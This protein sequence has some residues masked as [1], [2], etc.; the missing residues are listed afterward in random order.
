MGQFFTTIYCL[1]DDLFGLELASYLAGEATERQQS[2]MF[3]SIGLAMIGISLLVAVIF[4]YVVNHPKLN[5]WWGWCIFLVINGLINYFLG[6]RW[7]LS[8]LLDGMMEKMDQTTGQLIPLGIMEN[9][10]ISFGFANMI[11]SMVTF[12]II[13]YL[14]KWGSTNVPRAPF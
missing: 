6:W 10:C 8:D 5:N 14:I 7:V 3:M 2:N 9:D 11:L 1:F 12:L 4:Y 13:S